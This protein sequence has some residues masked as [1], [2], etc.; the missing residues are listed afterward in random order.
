MSEQQNKWSI[1]AD[2]LQACSCD[3]GCPC[4]F[5]APQTRGFCEGTGACRIIKGNYG[6]VPL[7]G[8]TVGFA[9]HWLSRKSLS[10]SF[11]W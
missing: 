7:D 5:S 6:D 4:E 3:Y 11:F 8:L 10:L 9:A 2:F 1:E